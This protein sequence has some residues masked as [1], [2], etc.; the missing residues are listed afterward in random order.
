MPVHFAGHPVKMEELV[1]WAR[2]KNLKII[3]DCAH[4]SGSLY[5]GKNLG[6]W[7]DIGCFSFEEKN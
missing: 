2:S 4:T 1:P 3:E 5:K 7:G 6:T